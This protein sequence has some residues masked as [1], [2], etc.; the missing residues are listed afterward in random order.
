VQDWTA[1]LGAVEARLLCVAHHT[2]A[3]LRV[4]FGSRPS[5]PLEDSIVLECIAA[6]GALRQSIEAERT[7]LQGVRQQCFELGVAL[8]E[9]RSQMVR[10]RTGERR[11]HLRALSDDLTSLP[12]RRHFREQ[13]EFALMRATC[14]AGAPAVLYLDLDGFKPINDTYGHQTGDDILRIVA[15]RLSRSVREA[16][17]V[18]RIGGDEFACLLAATPGNARAA[19][20]AIKLRAA[21]AAPIQLGD[22]TLSIQASIGIASSPADGA[23]ADALLRSA[24]A[25]MYEAKRTRSGYAFCTAPVPPADPDC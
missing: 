8:N 12:N 11:A 24:D 17:M 22:L 15:A 23:T 21:V 10:L 20:L 25:A 3:P 19:H 4:R 2:P 5:R 9:A 18:S 16:D 1:R 7:R 6:L 14:G 13:L